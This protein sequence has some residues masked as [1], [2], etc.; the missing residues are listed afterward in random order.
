MVCVS[1]SAAAQ[2]G[3]Y[4]LA[5]ASATP[6][7]NLESLEVTGQ[8]G[9]DYL[10]G[11]EPKEYLTKWS[12][13]AKN[14]AKAIFT[15]EEAPVDDLVVYVRD[16]ERH[17]HSVD[18]PTFTNFDPSLLDR[19]SELF[20]RPEF[21]LTD[22]QV[23]RKHAGGCCCSHRLLFGCRLNPGEGQTRRS[24]KQQTPA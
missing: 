4:K 5:I 7:L 12:H 2:P 15:G 22:P 14:L 11:E 16:G 20:H 3:S 17:W 24:K 1:I 23:S 6:G 19:R 18:N 8:G 21:V 10:D 13:I 9:I